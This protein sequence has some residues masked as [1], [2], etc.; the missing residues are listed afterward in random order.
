MTKKSKSKTP[1]IEI[2]RLSREE[3]NAEAQSNLKLEI[4]RMVEESVREAMSGKGAE[5]QPFFGSNE[6]AYEIKR[7]QTVHEQNKF[8]YFFE[9]WGC[10][11]CGT[12][13][14]AHRSC[15]MCLA[16]HTRIRQR[17]IGSLRKRQPPKDSIQPTFMDNVR[18]AREALNP[19]T[20]PTS[21]TAMNRSEKGEP[22]STH[23]FQ[24]QT[25]ANPRRCNFERSANT[26][27]AAAGPS[28]ASTWTLVSAGPK[29]NARSLIV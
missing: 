2:V 25:M 18:M 6:V 24:P 23:A 8:S 7:R 13:K 9:D 17:I 15:G 11:I 16:C 20:T 14:K 22:P 26:V 21:H 12:R 3:I 10:M 19:A 4:S 29:R 28:L 5:L 27:N 1:A